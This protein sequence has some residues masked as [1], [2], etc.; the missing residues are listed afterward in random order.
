MIQNGPVIEPQSLKFLRDIERHG[1]VAL[2]SSRRA[3]YNIGKENTR[4]A[5]QLIIRGPKTG[6]LYRI[7]GR[8]RRHRAS[9]PGEAPANL[10]GNLQ[11]KVNFIV[12]G[13]DEM[14]FGDQA[15]Y[16]LFLE[17][18]TRKMK[19]RPHLSTTVAHNQAF[20]EKEL[21]LRPLQEFQK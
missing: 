6:R 5:R 18:G 16:G 2:N 19:P 10:T 15:P 21:G 8:K 9:A 17:L 12:N 4:F 7:K 14:Q 3:L 1:E 13:H 11:K 20:A